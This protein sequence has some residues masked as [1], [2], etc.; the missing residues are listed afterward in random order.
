MR[1]LATL[2]DTEHEF[3]FEELGANACA[4]RLGEQRFELDLRRVGAS[5][6]SVLIG[7]RSFDFD[8][9]PEGEEVIVTSRAGAWRVNLIDEK[10]RA[11][12]AQRR[13]AAKRSR[14]TQGDDARARGQRAGEAGRRNRG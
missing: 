1:Y 10:R 7:N 12:R 2:R 13:P 5:S 3:E 9:T 14:R 4:V 11:M 8:V 6:F